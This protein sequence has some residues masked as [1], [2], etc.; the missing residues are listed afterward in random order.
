MHSQQNHVSI[1]INSIDSINNI[2]CSNGWLV[3]K[4]NCAPILKFQHHCKQTNKQIK[5]FLLFSM[6]PK[7]KLIHYACGT[8]FYPRMIWETVSIC[9]RVFNTAPKRNISSQISDQQKICIIGLR[10]LVMQAKRQHAPVYAL[11][12]LKC[13]S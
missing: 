3:Q 13:K 6:L 12:I 7:S 2:V 1:G 10:H 11:H 4:I 8:I 5:Q 9:L